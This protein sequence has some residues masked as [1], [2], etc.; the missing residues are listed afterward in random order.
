M[1]LPLLRLHLKKRSAMDVS[2]EAYVTFLCVCVFRDFLFLKAYEVGTH[3][4]CIDKSM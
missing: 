2:N 3:L 1:Y 4:N